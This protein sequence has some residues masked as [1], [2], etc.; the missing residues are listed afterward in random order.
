[1]I[2]LLSE[3]WKRS[4]A[5]LLLGVYGVSFCAP[6]YANGY[7]VR[8]YGH[9][10]PV[11]ERLDSRPYQGGRIGAL[12]KPNVRHQKEIGKADIYG[13]GKGFKGYKISGPSQ[14]EMNSFKSVGV[15]N[16]VNLFTGDFSYNIPLLDVGG[17]PVNIFYNAGITMD[18]EASWVGLGWNLNPGTVSRSL[19]GLP[20]DFDGVVSNGYDKITKQNY[21]QPNITVGLDATSKKEVLGYQHMPA[22]TIQLNTVSSINVGISYNN[23]TGFGLD[24]GGSFKKSKTIFTH[25]DK[26]CS[27]FNPYTTTLGA[28]LTLSSKSG[29]S[30]SPTF[31]QQL[32]K[33]DKNGNSGNLSTS[34]SY[35][36]RAGLKDF[37][38]DA[39]RTANYKANTATTEYSKIG[40]S[41]G[42]T[43]NFANI[44][45][46]PTIRMP[47]TYRSFN[48]NIQLGKENPVGRF[49]APLSLDGY[50]TQ[51][52]ISEA[53]QT[54]TKPAFGYLNMQDANGQDDALLDFNR[55]ND[56]GYIVDKTP[57]ISIPQYTYDV[58]NI[59]GEGTGGSFRAYRGDIG[60]VHDAYTKS[61]SIKGSTGFDLGTGGSS[62]NIGV[63]LNGTTSKTFV[64]EWADDNLAKEN[65]TF[66]TAT[67]SNEP[68]YFRNPGETA[69]STQTYYD[70]IGD[71]KLVRMQLINTD[72]ELPSATQN[73]LSYQKDGYTI[74]KSP[75]TNLDKTLPLSVAVTAKNLNRDKRSQIISYLTAAEA[76]KIGFDK[77]IKSYIPFSTNS[78]FPCNGSY[79]SMDRTYQDGNGAATN[80]RQP[81]HI[82]EIDVVEQDGK[83]YVYGLPVYNVEQKD[84]T[85]AVNRPSTINGSELTQYSIGQNSLNGTSAADKS[86][87]KSYTSEKIPAYA[88]SFLLTALL[89]PDYSDLTGDGITDDDLGTAVKFNYKRMGSDGNG[90]WNNYAWRT[91]IE[92][93][94]IGTQGGVATYNEGLKTDNSDDKAFYSCGQKELWYGHSIESKSMVAIF[95][96]SDR[97]DGLPVVRK[98]GTNDPDEDGGV[99]E[100]SNIKLQKLEKIDLYA[101]ADLIKN[102][103]NAK[104]I[105]TVHFEYSY[106]LCGN[107]SNSAIDPSNPSKR[108]GKLTLKSIY[109]TY[110]GATISQKHKYVFRYNNAFNAKT[111]DYDRTA[112]DCW[113]NLKTAYNATNGATA[114]TA[115]NP[116]G[117]L[118]SDY[119]FAAQS[120]DALNSI[121]YTNKKAVLDAFAGAWNLSEVDLPSGATIKVGYE[122]DDYA[123]VQNRPATQMMQIAGFGASS[124]VI[125]SGQLYDEGITALSYSDRG[126]VFF[127]VPEPISSS[128]TQNIQNEINQKY[129]NRINQLLLKLYVKVNTDGYGS[130]YEPIIIYAK[131][132]GSLGDYTCGLA[133]SSNGKPNTRI[134][135]KLA[136]NGSNDDFSVIQGVFQ[137]MRDHLTSKVYP[138]SDVKQDGAATQIIESILGMLGSV[139]KL[140]GDGLTFKRA[141]YGKKID[142]TRSFARL[143]NPIGIKFGGGHRVKTIKIVDNWD[144]LTTKTANGSST[145]LPSPEFASEYGQEYDYTN[146]V[147]INGV[148]TKT[149]SGVASY[150]PSSAGEENPFREMLEYNTTQFAGPASFGSIEMPIAE[151]YYPSAMVGYSKVRVRSI[152]NKDVQN[153]IK[154]GTGVQ[155]TEFYTTK[156]FPTVSDF[157][158][159]VSNT[160]NASNC[161]FNP[162]DIDLFLKFFSVDFNTLS[163]GFRVQLNNMNG[164]IKQ[165]STYPEDDPDHPVQYTKY[166]YRTDP[167]TNNPNSLYNKVDV[168]NGAKGDITNNTTIGKDIELMVDFREH[169]ATSYSVKL[170][171]NLEAQ[172][173]FIYFP[174]FF[175][176]YDLDQ[177]I[178]RSV[179]VMKVVNTYGI[180]ERVEAYDK[181]SKVNT[182]NL[183][184]DAETG[185]PLVTSSINTFNKP[186]YSY[187]YPAYWAYDGMGPAYKNIDVQ[188]NH[189]FIRNGFIESG[190][191]DQTLL[192]SG[193]ELYVNDASTVGVPDNDYCTATTCPPPKPLSTASKVWVVDLSKDPTYTGTK[194]IMLLERDGTPYNGGDVYFRV[195]RSG[196]RNLLGASVGAISSL[197]NPVVHNQI[198]ITADNIL[199]ASAARFKEKWRTDD[200]FYVKDSWVTET[201]WVYPKKIILPLLDVYNLSQRR[202]VNTSG[203]YPINNQHNSP[204]LEAWKYDMSGNG[205]DILSMS[206][207]GFDV[208]N[209]PMPNNIVSSKLSLYAHTD[210]NVSCNGSVSVNHRNKEDI[211]L[212]SPYAQIH[213]GVTSHM[214]S[215]D[216]YPGSDGNNDAKLARITMPWPGSSSQFKG[217]YQD[218]K[219]IDQS[220]QVLVQTNAGPPILGYEAAS[221]KSFTKVNGFDNRLDVTNMVKAMSGDRQLDNRSI[222]GI[223]ISL[224]GGPTPTN[225]DNVCFTGMGACNAPT[226]DVYYLDC[227]NPPA[228]STDAT[229]AILNTTYPCPSTSLVHTCI[230][231]FDQS[232]FNPYVYGMLGNWRA[233]KS[234]TF[235]DDRKES[236]IAAAPNPSTDGTLKAFETFW[237][238]DATSNRIL[239]KNTD[240][241]DNSTKWVWNIAIAQVNKRGMEIENYDPLGRY[242]AGL[243]GYNQSLP[244]AVTNNAHYCESAFDGFE[245]YGFSDELCATLCKP[246]RHFDL[247]D[248]AAKLDNTQHHSGSYSLRVDAG[249]SQSINVPVKGYNGIDPEL[250]LGVQNSTNP[251]VKVDLAGNGLQAVY[252]WN[253][254]NNFNPLTS[255]RTLTRHN[256]LPAISIVGCSS[257]DCSGGCNQQFK[258]PDPTTLPNEQIINP[259]NFN[260]T[261]TGFI[262]VDKSGLYQFYIPDDASASTF[263][264]SNGNSVL[265]Y[266]Q[267]GTSQRN[268][269][270][271]L[272]AGNFYNI[273]I[274]YHKACLGYGISILWK[275]PCSSPDNPSNDYQPIEKKYLYDPPIGVMLTPPIPAYVPCAPGDIKMTGNVLT[276]KF[277]PTP[278][279]KMVFSAW[280]KEGSSDCHC[281]NYPNNSVQAYFNNDPSTALPTPLTPTGIII[282]GWQRYEGVIQVPLNATSMQ[283]QLN[284]SGQS[285]A[286]F[287][288]VR[289][290][291]FNANMKS[292]VYDPATLRLK[293]EL[294]ENNFASFYEYDD[295]GTLTRVKKETK[296]GIKTIQ[297]TRSALRQNQQ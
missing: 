165:Q 237:D 205:D 223:R 60:Y 230:S 74:E 59:S 82:S 14:P 9:Q 53:D 203:S 146:S 161:H 285:P 96:T 284:N 279:S 181:G 20:D 294:D 264:I 245:D 22:T 253:D 68:V 18:Q 23:Y 90:G 246:T 52:Y 136:N 83:R 44:S 176:P 191:V 5:S 204:Y 34:F 291:P 140:I 91:P 270:A 42:F 221:N 72:A 278:G 282:E 201:Q 150:E 108:L 24:V 169:N 54:T 105:K 78:P 132:D 210:A 11:P 194:R 163:Q 166:I 217:A 49:N 290:H 92:P 225:M 51:S 1:M 171:F 262:Q 215:F 209:L 75:I 80:Y 130:G 109:F 27:D 170:N 144:M 219:Y 47:I 206:W 97:Q 297:E 234:Y 62:F 172:P 274:T 111:F 252:N 119:Q 152:H 211:L 269:S 265:T 122:S 43:L 2:D 145:N 271:N 286:F 134:W 198:T 160:P 65:L 256:D 103:A 196:R 6:L 98:A 19:R 288:D 77:P 266:W 56:V 296:E 21:V 101:K 143:T 41:G 94:T 208:S 66:Q 149:S 107:V 40:V 153:N 138:G 272:N 250:T 79:I 229:D 249:S 17:Y 168:V 104:P 188:Y 281:T 86:K 8:R 261:W 110:N 233:F 154:S 239:P 99:D 131:M 292:F 255:N 76:M 127:D 121:D 25:D 16:M 184:Y 241:A 4:M 228:G 276:D 159:L 259:T 48:L 190:F 29:L 116:A 7:A 35:N 124:T 118:N 268:F 128:G 3:R 139:G 287:D 258:M 67:G 167:V 135:V 89:S 260:V 37:Q 93:K 61:N 240:V 257:M 183:V 214:I 182:D 267:S 216:H 39:Q 64:G 117:L 218:D 177:N 36:S 293:A 200:A 100:N 32:F 81:N 114:T 50:Y 15:D 84:V 88:H 157:T 227:A 273:S 120:S 222:D 73:L 58:F 232:K 12:L 129:L 133:N 70:A 231:V 197:T 212:S 164:K 207:L 13:S 238:Y 33:V 180:L 28:N 195:V 158:P 95:T 244:V 174:S 137:F 123:S 193:D 295:E 199:N 185:E 186:V 147:T 213:D 10:M 156:D 106:D 178:F 38:M 226:L 115:V 71:D 187:H 202:K 31:S 162:N 243:Y 87:D 220:T 236:N 148:T 263:K 63:N 275:L 175:L 151:G 247:G 283:V 85:F 142:V 280:V 113:G 45:Y 173:P 112:H 155:E 235:Y 179:S 55:M 69:T 248:I 277:S 192:Q 125:P 46:T 126:Y 30:F 251:V 254:E 26:T 189:V 141:G 224:T 57:A 289:L 242:N 102:G